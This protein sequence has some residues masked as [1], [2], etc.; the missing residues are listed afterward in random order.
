MYGP[1]I[2]SDTGE[3]RIRRNDELKNMFQKP[4]NIAGI[5]RKRFMWAGHAWRKED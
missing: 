5:T 3:W 2:D 4:A 1:C